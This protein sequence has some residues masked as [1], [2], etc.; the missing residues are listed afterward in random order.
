MDA[1][2]FNFIMR[3]QK[4]GEWCLFIN[5]NPS[6]SGVQMHKKPGKLLQWQ[7]LNCSF[8]RGQWEIGIIKICIYIIIKGSLDEKLPSYEVLKMLRE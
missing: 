4:I 5:W 6:F 8:D 2:E 1:S 3:V 7:A